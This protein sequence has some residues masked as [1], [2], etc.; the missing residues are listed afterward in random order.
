MTGQLQVPVFGR[1]LYIH[2]LIVGCL[3]ILVGVQAAIF[4]MFMGLIGGIFPAVRAARLAPT[5]ALAGP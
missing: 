1:N 5:E 4:A 3:L 2:S